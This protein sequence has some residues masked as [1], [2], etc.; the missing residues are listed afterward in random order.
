[1]FNFDETK[2]ILDTKFFTKAPDE[3]NEVIVEDVEKNETLVDEDQ[4]PKVK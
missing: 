4:F 2:Y 3:V 1:M